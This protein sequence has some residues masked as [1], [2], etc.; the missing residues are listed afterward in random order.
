LINAALML[1]FLI[2][3]NHFEISRW[4]SIVI[5]LAI[6]IAN[7]RGIPLRGDG[8]LKAEISISKYFAMMLQVVFLPTNTLSFA[9]K[10]TA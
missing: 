3:K 7:I 10:K 4:K 5:F 9:R 2:P 8:F 1:V 6:S